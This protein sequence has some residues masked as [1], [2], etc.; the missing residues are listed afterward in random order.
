MSKKDRKAEERAGKRKK[1]SDKEQKRL[2]SMGVTELVKEGDICFDAGNIRDAIKIY[3]IAIKQMSSKLPNSASSNRDQ[4]TKSPINEVKSKLFIAYITRANELKNKNMLSEAKA[5][6]KQAMASIHSPLCLDVTGM[7][8]FLKLSTPEDVFKSYNDFYTNKKREQ[9]SLDL[10]PLE[11]ILAEILIKHNCWEKVGILNDDILIKR[12]APVAKS[13]VLF[14]NSGDWDAA[15][16]SM[17]SISRS[18]PFAHIRLFCKAMS[19]FYKDNDKEM[20]KA[21]SMIPKESMFIKITDTLKYGVSDNRLNTKSNLAINKSSLAI[22]KCLWRGS[23]DIYDKLENII[24]N[25][26]KEN[27]NDYLQKNIVE[28]ATLLMPEHTD[29]VIQFIL[30]TLCQL[31]SNNEHHFLKM[32][33]KL[34]KKKGKI[35][36]LKRDAIFTVEI[37]LSGLEYF[38]Y[39]EEEFTTLEEQ[40]MA[41]SMVIYHIAATIFANRAYSVVA[42]IIKKEPRYATLLGIT[43][44]DGDVATLQMIA[45]GV[46]ID[47]NNSSLYD[48]ALKIPALSNECKKVIETISLAKCEAFPDDPE[49]LLQIASLYH[50]KNAY[51]KAESALQKALEL[52]PHDSRVLDLHVISLLISA[53][54]S[55]AKKKF[56]LSFQDVE[57]AKRFNS[58]QCAILI[59]EKSIFYKIAE[60]SQANPNEIEE[61]FSLFSLSEKLKCYALLMAD[62]EYRLMLGKFESL[63]SS[64]RKS[65]KVS[66]NKAESPNSLA[67]DPYSVVALMFKDNLKRLEELTS[68]DILNL[69]LPLP[70]EW[71][72]LFNR[73]DLFTYFD[74]NSNKLIL[75]RLEDRDLLTLIEKID[76]YRA[77]N[78]F[79]EELDNRIKAANKG[80][81]DRK[82]NSSNKSLN[83]NIENS[84][85]DNKTIE[86]SKPDSKTIENSKLDSKILEF[87]K[88][89]LKNISQTYRISDRVIYNEYS[90]LIS[91]L[92]PE[93]EKILKDAS[94]RLSKKTTGRFKDALET[95][96]FDILLHPPMMPHNLFDDYYDDEYYDDDD[97]EGDDF[98][99]FSS[100]R[101]FNPFAQLDELADDFDL[102]AIPSF[103]LKMVQKDLKKLLNTPDGREIRKSLDEAIVELEELVDKLNLRSKSDKELNETKKKILKERDYK[104]KIMMINVCY[105]EEAMKKFSKE[106]KILFII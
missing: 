83:L 90:E 21:I 38:Q 45:F 61:Q 43:S 94:I 25:A 58:K 40:K 57:K 71:I 100:K 44:K 104:M 26:K 16:E 48:L 66:K 74:L 106:A 67:N 92:D 36:R 20:L 101:G 53:D 80:K 2:L 1:D 13:A 47:P 55:A 30:E 95:F 64:Y 86:N 37:F 23:F 88:V 60:N 10:T 17:K 28:F 8:L 77:F 15:L 105:K 41:K 50:A 27:Y 34:L 99:P 35:F 73:I 9:Q 49:P 42:K 84:K 12:D 51:R 70:N 72:R 81:V 3:Q 31:H 24:T 29:S 46:K 103:V 22:K 63:P 75:K 79:I 69:L 93:T 4:Y 11:R 7:G 85:S 65:N 82:K 56:N 54:K 59:A 19:A 97:S 18:S 5:I 14:M 32:A 68:W 91:N 96:R 76:D 39:L 62:M 102:S 52:A 89:T 78:R 6:E 87:Y 33:D 98:D